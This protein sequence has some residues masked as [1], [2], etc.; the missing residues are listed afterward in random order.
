MAESVKAWEE[1]VIIP[2]YPVGK[3]DKNPM[4]IENRV[5]QGSS[6]VVYPY[7]IIEK[8]FDKKEDK[9]YKAAFLENE[10]IK[11]MILPELGGRVQMAYDKIKGR[12]FIYY[13]Q[14]IKPQLVGL[15]GPWI[16]GGI[17]F[18]WPQHH[19]PS[20]FMPIDHS[21]EHCDDGSAI[22]WVNEYERMFH[23]KGAAGF[24]LRPG[25]ARLEVIGRL[26]NPTPFPQTF[27]WWAN[28]AVSVND[29]YES[30]F[31][32]DVSAVYDH[33]RRDVSRYPIATGTYY[34]VDYSA[35]VDI[36]KYKNIPVPTSYMAVGSKYNFIGGYR[37]D[38]QAGVV[39][40]ADHHVSPGKKQWTWGN[41]D[42]GRSWYD[43]LTDS[44]GP[45]IEI[46]AGVFTDNQPDF[47]WMQPYEE[48]SF[49]Q[50]FIPYRELGVIKDA[51]ADL[52]MNIF[53]KGNSAV[54][55]LQATSELHGVRISVRKSGREVF[56]AVKD[57]DPKNVLEEAVD[58]SDLENIVVEAYSDD[59][60]R[61]IHWEAEP[62]KALRIPE[63]AK[64]A[65]D[66]KDI[67]ENE[68]LYL[69]GLHL[70]QYR[71]ATYSPTDYYLEALSRD[72]GDVRNNNAMG[73]WLLRRGQFAKSEGYFRRAVETLTE[74]NPNPYDCEPYYNLGLSLK[75]QGR[76]DEAYD[77]FYKSCWDEAWKGPG[78]F[79]LAQISVSRHEW[80]TALQEIDCALVRNW[81]NLS[82]RHLKAIILRHLG[83]KDEALDLISESL[84]LDG[85]NYGCRFEEY[86][87]TEDEEK[88]NE[89]ASLMRDEGHNYEELSYS[90]AA[91]GC[92]NEAIKVADWALGF[93]KSE[94]TM[95]YYYKGWFLMSLGRADEAKEA[96]R[97]AE[98]LQSGD[99]FPNSLEAILALESAI[100]LLVK[101]PKAHF[102]LGNILYDKRQ[103]AEAISHWEASAKE[104][105]DFPT[106]FRNL[107]LA[108]FNKLGR[109]EEAVK[110]M[111][112]AY[113]M[114]ENDGRVLMELDQL[115]GKMNMS[116][117]QRLSFLEKHKSVAFDRDDLYLTYITLLNDLGRYSEALV[118]LMAH[119]FHP[120]EGGEGKVAAQY[121]LSCSEIAKQYLKAK[122]YAKALEYID[123]CFVYP[124]NLGEGKLVMAKEN[125][126]NYIKGCILEAAGKEAEAMECF[127]K[128]SI[129]DSQP[130][131]A[132]Y[133]ND[134]KPD[135]IFYKG[136]ALRKLG[137]EDQAKGC[138]NRLIDFGE[139]H[140]EDKYKPDY[141][142]VSL[143][144]LSVLDEDMDKRNKVHC[145]YLI[146]LGQLGLGN[147]EKAH[148]YLAEALRL[149]ITHQGALVHS[150]M[151]DDPIIFL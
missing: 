41:C 73:L 30:V 140:L 27:L 11:V 145:C 119:K 71:H 141:F 77:S 31:P 52:L 136:L 53:M 7:P 120:W 59:G 65:M 62:D 72:A 4:F 68:Q 143:P 132:I 39:H 84:K 86:L 66:P 10:Y 35:G 106:V 118:M 23:Q 113:G 146:G 69:T 38:E 55:K 78:Y 67:K 129:G 75:Y 44:N 127:R 25:C 32:S 48:K 88:L 83:R 114:N 58:V 138:F 13:N 96:A 20:T 8:I 40:V 89:L 61:L 126:F 107:A 5:Y 36:S 105:P 93:I 131:E 79:S 49:V 133:Y 103:Y 64:P 33:G 104:G 100:K 63:P 87:L 70:E 115:Y 47:S 74:K 139:N 22:V 148:E 135:K 124:E 12:H 149:D 151:V 101:A 108:Y 144:T 95:L 14:V 9:A 3:P 111:E 51:S 97:K 82:A 121:Q 125:D 122:E 92:W 54:L 17:E 134:Q 85:F 34:K 37:E 80:E 2:T 112:K 94:R 6:G 91:A 45:Y 1:N 76:L 147:K 26:F 102:Y 142:A 46:M 90:Y 137:L 99:C 57:L 24:R 128:A 60:R 109:K 43:N 50:Y 130:S 123:K 42:F 15:L 116:Y 19:R 150:A 98:S 21:I 18:N 110:L 29:Y 28:P 81:H 117:S 56:S 16:S